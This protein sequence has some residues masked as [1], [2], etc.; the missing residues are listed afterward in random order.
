M[1][2]ARKLLDI[3]SL[4]QLVPLNTLSEELLREV[5]K[6]AVIEQ[7]RPGKF[8]FRKGMRDHFACYLLTGE[9][10][11][12]R[13]RTVEGVI[14]GGTPKALH[15][16]APGMPRQVSA[17]ARTAVTYVRIDAGLLDV[18]LEWDQTARYKVTEI[19]S[20]E[21]GDW[22]TRLLQSDLFQQLPATTIQKVL[23][24]MQAVTTRA[25]QVIVREEEEGDYFYVVKSGSC[26]VTR[27][28][29]GGDGPVKLAELM[30][31]DAFGEEALISGEKRNATVTMSCDGELMRL[32]R[33]DF[34]ELLQKPLAPPLPYE[35]ARSRV[36]RG[37]RW[38]DVR[39]PQEF[40]AAHLPEAV[41]IPLLELRNRLQALSP[42]HEYIVCCETGRRSASAAFVLGQRGFN[43]AVLKDGLGSVPPDHLQAESGD[44]AEIIDF[45]PPKGEGGER[46]SGAETRH[47]AAVDPRLERQLR[48]ALEKVRASGRQLADLRVARARAEARANE[49]QSQLEAANSELEELAA[50]NG[51]LEK[52]RDRLREEMESARADLERNRRELEPMARRLKELEAEVEEART[53]VEAAEGRAASIEAERQR[54]DEALTRL[55]EEGERVESDL[56][57][58]KSVLETRIGELE[59][60]QEELR[61]R[62]EGEV[63]N[64]IAELEA[65][66]AEAEAARGALEVERDEAR[67]RLER[68]TAALQ[69]EMEGL[70]VER[71]RLEKERDEGAIE[72]TGRIEQLERE[73]GEAGEALQ[74][75]EG[76]REE[77]LRRHE[78]EM[79]VLRGELDSRA[80]E[81]ERLRAELQ[82]K[83]AEIH[84]LREAHEAELARQREVLE[85]S[86]NALGEELEEARREL[87]LLGGRLQ[88]REAGLAG[89]EQARDEALAARE[90]LE[91]ELDSLRRMLQ[92]QEERVAQLGH[93]EE[94]SQA[95]SERLVEAETAEQE[96]RDA[97][98][99]LRQEIADLR[100]QSEF[101]A[102]ALARA[103]E[104]QARLQAVIDEQG[105]ELEH[106]RPELEM[107]QQRLGEADEERNALREQ[108]GSLESIREAQAQELEALNGVRDQLEADLDA[109]RRDLE[110]GLERQA[111]RIGLIEAQKGRLEAEL[112]QLRLLQRDESAQGQVLKALQEQLEEAEQGRMEAEETLLRLEEEVAGLRAGGDAGAEGARHQELERAVVAAREAAAEAEARTRALE[113]ERERLAGEMQSLR[114][115]LDRLRQARDEEQQYL[116]SLMDTLESERRA[117]AGREEEQKRALQRIAEE[118]ERLEEELAELRD[119]AR[120]RAGGAGEKE[121][122]VAEL[123]EALVAIREERDRL[124]EE[125]RRAREEARAK[126]SEL[127][128]LQRELEENDAEVRNWMADLNRELETAQKRVTV[129]GARVEELEQERD[130]LARRVE[131]AESA[132]AGEEEI[133][134][135]REAANLELQQLVGELRESQERVGSLERELEA[136]QREVRQKEDEVRR[137]TAEL[138]QARLHPAEEE[139][140][141]F[142]PEPWS[143][144]L[145]KMQDLEETVARLSEENDELRREIERLAGEQEIAIGVGQA[146]T[147]LDYEG[148]ARGGGVA[149]TRA[150]ADLSLDLDFDEDRP[151]KPSPEERA[152]PVTPPSPPDDERLFEPAPVA[153]SRHLNDRG[154]WR[155]WWILLLLAGLGS[156]AAWLLLARPGV[157]PTPV[158][159]RI[160]GILSVERGTAADSGEEGGAAEP[161]GADQVVTESPPAVES[162]PAGEAPAVAGSGE[163]PPSPPP[164]AKE[165]AAR[166]P[167]QVVAPAEPAGAIAESPPAPSPGSPPKEVSSR[168]P[169][170]AAVPLTVAPEEGLEAGV[171]SAQEPGSAVQ[172]V[173][174]FQDYLNGGLLGPVLVEVPAGTFTMGSAG[175]GGFP[176]EK[177]AYLI[178]V[179]SFAIAK[180]ETTWAE[181]AAW[182]Q[183]T[184]QPVDPERLEDTRPVTGVTWN[185]VVAYAQWLSAQTGHTYRLPRE[186]EWEYAARA[187]TRGDW[188]WGDEPLEGVANCAGCGSQWDGR[189]PAPAG[190]FPPNPLGIHDSAGNVLEWTADCYR[191]SYSAAPLEAEVPPDCGLRVARGGSFRDGVS[192][193]RSA[194]RFAFD[195]QTAREDLGFR[196]VREP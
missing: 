165:K 21:D 95:L 24:R 82:A 173:R 27:D 115:E 42:D 145:E 60:A 16:L 14:K 184:G 40:A 57:R 67:Q 116:H 97:L 47:S 167:P 185:D 162:P 72:L 135:I 153:A 56:R 143:P 142:A 175:E 77:A 149:E 104:E 38:L 98:E 192:E 128:A 10:E 134:S 54:L 9:V 53:S 63:R 2:A 5:S 13:D 131:Q 159:E 160:D 59:S 181:Y 99:A 191:P 11:L 83:E 79:E 84:A 130:D 22:M 1:V 178:T 100:Q 105:A 170:V 156:A 37:A 78:R 180:Y 144:D 18:M 31:G 155:W 49:L 168:A 147:N 26:S 103:G 90:V 68:E 137:L 71:D 110:E 62:L 108:I 55:T 76:E 112:E 46:E 106:L 119:A 114:E 125:G 19:D 166:L 124:E 132:G 15:P 58:E 36:A 151:R 109:A 161:G 196:L 7:L 20:E 139:S 140:D 188:W 81:E 158:R 94:E 179:P 92:E 93:L 43:A 182:L 65:A 17:R 89:L 171:S 44:G 122:R 120:E 86:R 12:L 141:P 176:D 33:E 133:A 169:A 123:E 28:L 50:R 129:L 45:P 85:E 4:G 41:N 152:T 183:A 127:L 23:T 88:E 193:L 29:P 80:A 48:A 51:D 187:G 177:P 126:E 150:L 189:G 87:E 107:L 136:R 146:V 74:S 118:K 138:E 35:E 64:R 195:P 111:T 32:A 69:Q 39:L 121:Q 194:R 75:L 190:S 113:E 172:A 154:G 186:A 61:E 34:H 52:E 30:P 8:L 117:A 164:P 73:L 148:S 163:A 101:D 70:R 66:L 102:E 157:L 6:K 3:K 91:A 96:A 174:T 25:G